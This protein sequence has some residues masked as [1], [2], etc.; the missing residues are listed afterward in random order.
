MILRA[1][2]SRRDCGILFMA[3]SPVGQ[4]RD[5]IVSVAGQAGT[6]TRNLKQ[7]DIYERRLK[8]ERVSERSCCFVLGSTSLSGFRLSEGLSHEISF[9][10]KSVSRN[11]KYHENS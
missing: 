5:G 3:G 11:P 4:K 9:G 10:D 6:Q 8:V 2:V 7:H 1:I